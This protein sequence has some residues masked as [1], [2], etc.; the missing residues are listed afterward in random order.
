[1]HNIR[2]AAFWTLDG[3]RGGSVRKV[4]LQLREM[5]DQSTPNTAALTEILRYAG[6]HVPYYQNITADALDA[7]PVID[8][9]VIKRDY[10]AFRSLEFQDDAKLTV[11]HTSG[12]SGTPFKA[13]RDPGKEIWHKAGLILQHEE[14]GWNVGD[15]WAHMRNWGFGAPAT[16]KERF[17]KNMVPLSVLNLD[18]EKL[19]KIVQTLLTDR[20]LQIVLGYASALERL[21][22]YIDDHY[23][24]ATDFGLKLIIADSDNLKQSAWDALERIFK[25]QV[26]NRYANIENGIIAITKPGD[27]TF[28]TNQSQVYVEVLKPDADASVSEGEMGRIVI[29]DLHNKAMPFIRYDTG[30]LAVAKKIVGGQCVALASLQGRAISSLRRTD[31]VLLSETNIMGRFK[32]FTEIGRYQII[33]KSAD[34]YEMLLESTPESADARCAAELKKIFGDDARV[35]IRHT[36]HIPLR[37]SGKFPVTVSEL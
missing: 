16:A 35:T 31:G 37:E 19:E 32:E 3:I 36:D 18:D 11:H 9:T 22:R 33:Q 10:S 2:E 8:K 23:D 12:S 27:R 26:L 15:R 34:E 13:F 4:Y 14:I 7:F 28:Y 20:K 1:M 24:E 30:D 25:C 17:M 21:A 5:R 6:E 29:T